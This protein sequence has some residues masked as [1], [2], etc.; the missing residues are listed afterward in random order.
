MSSP[1]SDIYTIT[2]DGTNRSIKIT[3][4]TYRD[5]SSLSDSG[6]GKT[7][8]SAPRN[9]LV[10]GDKIVVPDSSPQ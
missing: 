8:F 7:L 1:L 2:T 9:C 5:V 3:Q 6:D 10:N 4:K